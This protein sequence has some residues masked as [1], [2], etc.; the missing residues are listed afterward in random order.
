M[1][2]IIRAKANANISLTLIALHIR[3]DVV[4]TSDTV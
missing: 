2:Y 4:E 1:K 3:I